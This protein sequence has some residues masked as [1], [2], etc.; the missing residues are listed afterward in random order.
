MTMKRTF[1]CLCFASVLLLADPPLGGHVRETTAVTW[2]QTI[3]RIMIERCGACHYEGGTAFSLMTYDD[4]RPWAVSIREEILS[5]SMPPW[6][7]VKG[8]G[9]FRND[10]ALSPAH[11]NMIVSWVE[12]GVP[13]GNPEDLP[14]SPEV[15]ETSIME[16]S[17]D[18]VPISGDTTLER[19][20]VVD[21]LRP[22]DVPREGSLQIT[23][24]LPNGRVEPL[25]WLYNYREEYVHPFLFET[26]IELPRGTVIRGLPA[27]SSV[28]L[29]PTAS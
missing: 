24:E 8:F 14:N 29:I 17:P 18:E 7:A 10:Q 16:R 25:L 3:S 23:A 20:L 6:G 11:T 2:N 4:A 27:G 19:R 15:S 21:G 28:A 22:L 13:E 26:P 9:T 1:T 5:R 12:G